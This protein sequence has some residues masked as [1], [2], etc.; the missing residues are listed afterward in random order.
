MRNKDNGAFK[1]FQEPFQP[2][3]SFDIEVVRRFIQQ[4]HARP[5]DQGTAQRRFTQPAAGKR[6]QLRV[7]VK[8]KLLD[9]FIDAAIQLP[10]AQVIQLF[11][12]TGQFI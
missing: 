2:V 4:Q 7:G 10:Q 12:Q 5:A 9:H 8:T 6:S 11:L 1:A 3:D